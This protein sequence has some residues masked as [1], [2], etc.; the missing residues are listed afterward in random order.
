MLSA[1]KDPAYSL[2]WKD[3]VECGDVWGGVGRGG[4]GGGVGWGGVGRWVG[5]VDG[6]GGLVVWCAVGWGGLDWVGV[7]GWRW[8]CFWIN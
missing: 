8:R 1:S 7:A 6:L 4:G 5:R 3:G 2:G